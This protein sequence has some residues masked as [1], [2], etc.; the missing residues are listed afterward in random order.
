MPQLD[1]R[2]LSECRAKKVKII[3]RDDERPKRPSDQVNRPS[4]TDAM[5]AFISRNARTLSA[6]SKA[7]APRFSAPRN[8]TASVAA[9]LFRRFLATQEQPRLRLGSTG[10][11]YLYQMRLIVY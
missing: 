9:P 6:F 5:A 3:H 1:P 11:D 10:D 2:C 7:A 4:T 8:A